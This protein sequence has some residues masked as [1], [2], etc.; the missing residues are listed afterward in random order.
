MH[1]ARLVEGVDESVWP[2]VLARS[3][4]DRPPELVVVD[5]GVLEGGREFAVDAVQHSFLEG[6]EPRRT[7]VLVL[8]GGRGP[9]EAVV[10]GELRRELRCQLFTGF[11]FG[12]VPRLLVVAHQHVGIRESGASTGLVP[13]DDAGDGSVAPVRFGELVALGL[14]VRRANLLRE[15]VEGRQ[16]EALEDLLR[17]VRGQELVGVV[18]PDVG[19][20]EAREPVP[21]VVDA[22]AV[23]GDADERDGFDV[24][25]G[26]PEGGT[27]EVALDLVDGVPEWPGS[28]V[29]GEL[30]AVVA[31]PD[32]GGGAHLEP[33]RG[34]VDEFLEPEMAGEHVG[35]VGDVGEWRGLVHQVDAF[36]VG[37]LQR[38]LPRRRRILLHRQTLQYPRNIFITTDK[39]IIRCGVGIEGMSI[40]A[41]FVIPTGAVPGGETLDA[42]PGAT[43]RLERVIPSDGELRPIFWVTG[44]DGERFVEMAQDED[45]IT[46]LQELVRLERSTLFMAVWT[47]EVPVVD[48]I[49]TLRASILDAVGTADRWVFQIRADDRDRVR[50][51]LD[52]FSEQGIQ[53]ELKRLSSISKDDV[54]DGELT[55]KQRKTLIAALEMGYFETPTEVSQEEIGE[56]FGVSGRAVSKRLRRG[57]K[58]LIRTTLESDGLNGDAATRQR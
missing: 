42:L 5:G 9:L 35:G 25:D 49:K 38:R 47:A 40:I 3:F 14:E 48:G 22:A 10:G 37:L 33:E 58:N 31:E 29:C 17:P 45:G 11:T 36:V 21:V 57:T 46:D 4:G 15:R 26:L 28:V 7:S 6:V 53:V 12:D 34:A 43:V 32:R 13:H 16:V 55:P 44:V 24:V 56:R 39:G 50:E 2:D 52:V 18:V 23:C 27:V 30:A 51:F 41:E 20:E 8:Q 1:P 19:P 54:S